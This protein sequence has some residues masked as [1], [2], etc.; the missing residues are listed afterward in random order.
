MNVTH[1]AASLVVLGVFGYAASPDIARG[2]GEGTGQLF[3]CFLIAWW[4][5]KTKTP[6]AKNRA[7]LAA[8]LIALVVGGVKAYE[9]HER[10]SAIQA[11]KT[12]LDTSI[13]R[14]AAAMTGQKVPTDS[15]P[16]RPP[17]ASANTKDREL[18]FIVQVAK[19]ASAHQKEF[20]EGLNRIPLQLILDPKYL[21]SAKYLAEG[22]KILR[23]YEDY[24]KLW[25]KKNN[26]LLLDF[27]AR[28]AKVFS[29]KGYQEFRIG[30][31]KNSELRQK[32]NATENEL[33]SVFRQIQDLAAQLIKTEQL[34]LTAEGQ[35]LFSQTADMNLYNRL[36]EKVQQLAKEE[37]RLGQVMIDRQR[38]NQRELS[39]ILQ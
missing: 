20:Y 24:K 3:F 1:F 22:R 5:G 11:L 28:G 35:L 37:E 32:I 14:Q 36:I 13:N 12:T 25:D 30:L 33:I 17:A 31:H 8:V 39:R 34:E 2:L 6:E 7:Y 29:K 21:T 38:E 15:I 19:E 27:E 18:N 10:D 26:Q 23:D 16:N 9:R 4:W